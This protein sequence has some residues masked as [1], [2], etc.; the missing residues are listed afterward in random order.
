MRNNPSTANAGPANASPCTVAP[1]P[2]RCARTRGVFGVA[3]GTATGSGWLLMRQEKGRRLAA[4]PSCVSL[5]ARE[6][7]LRLRLERR[8]LRAH[9]AGA[10]QDAL[11]RRAPV[12][13]ERTGEQVGAVEAEELRRLDL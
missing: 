11:Q 2:A 10:L 12:V 6:G 13:P 7:L 5:A 8:Q 1:H 4:P 9:A 3:F